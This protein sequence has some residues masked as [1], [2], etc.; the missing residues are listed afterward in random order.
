[1]ESSCE[2]DLQMSM[3]SFERHCISLVFGM[4]H[5]QKAGVR[6]FQ[7]FKLKFRLNSFNFVYGHN[8]C[9]H[10]IF[11]RNKLIKS[12]HELNA[13]P[14]ISLAFQ[15]ISIR[16]WLQSFAVFDFLL[17][18]AVVGLFSATDIVGFNLIFHSFHVCCC[19]A[20]TVQMRQSWQLTVLILKSLLINVLH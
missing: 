15:C 11:N 2:F 8:D 17:Y 1:M 10:K 19:T 14:L 16:L 20:K 7:S 12:C 3:N 13:F 4:D 5:Q 18:L 6:Q 9:S